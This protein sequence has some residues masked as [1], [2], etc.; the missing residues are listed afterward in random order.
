MMVNQLVSLSSIL[1][2]YVDHIVQSISVINKNDVI[3]RLLLFSSSKQIKY[4]DSLKND[5][6]NEALFVPEEEEE[7]EDVER[8]DGLSDLDEL[9]ID[10]DVDV[11]D[12]GEESGEERGSNEVEDE[13][14]EHDFDEVFSDDE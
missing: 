2:Q 11:D 5:D 4:K 12:V 10:N 14:G 13:T 9:N 1:K 6:D 3:S 8:V 7:E